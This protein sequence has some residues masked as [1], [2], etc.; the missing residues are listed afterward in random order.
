M[1]L[2]ANK[3][4]RNNIA[5]FKKSISSMVTICKKKIDLEFIFTLDFAQILT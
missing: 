2:S 3:K 1:P 4:M 5:Y